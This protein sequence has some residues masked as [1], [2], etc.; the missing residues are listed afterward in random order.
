MTVAE[1]VCE[2]LY[3]GKTR[4]EIA[5]YDD[6]FMRWVLCRQRDGNG[7][8]IRVPDGLPKWAAKHLDARGQW[9]IRNPQ[10]FGSMFRQ[11]KKQQGFSEVEQRQAWE[12]WRGENPRFGE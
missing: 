4:A 3:A 2:L 8:L 1:L 11:V 10:P 7:E 5:G 9:V 12:E 6:A